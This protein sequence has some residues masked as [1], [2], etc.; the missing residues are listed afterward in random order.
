MVPGLVT[1]P[2]KLRGRSANSIRTFCAPPVVDPHYRTEGYD[3]DCLTERSRVEQE[4]LA[5]RALA[6]FICSLRRESLWPEFSANSVVAY[7]T[8]RQTN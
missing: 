4:I 7:C 2:N 3:V 6:P 5:S 8:L 1:R